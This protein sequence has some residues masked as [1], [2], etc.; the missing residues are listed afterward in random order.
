MNV[1]TVYFLLLKNGKIYT[2]ITND[3]E[4]RISEHFEELDP[5]SYT[6]RFKVEKLL[7]YLEFPSPN[8]AIDAEKKIKKWSRAKKMALL[9]QDW[10]TLKMLSKKYFA[11]VEGEE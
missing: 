6:S 3:L 5:K 10:D 2:G 11:K 1:F 7:G 4:R 8:E 9:N